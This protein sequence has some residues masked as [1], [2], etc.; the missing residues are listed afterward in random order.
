MLSPKSLQYHNNFTATI[1]KPSTKKNIN[2]FKNSEDPYSINGVPSTPSSN[3][4]SPPP[5]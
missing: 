4:P 5:Q 2:L 3:F 1:L